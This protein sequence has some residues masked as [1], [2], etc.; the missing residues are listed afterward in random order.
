MSRRGIRQIRRISPAGVGAGGV[1]LPTQISGLQFWVRGDLGITLNGSNVS[2]WADQSGN[3]RNNTQGTAALQPAYNTTDANY[4]NQPTLTFNQTNTQGF[5]CSTFTAVP[6]PLTFI[7]VC[8]YATAVHTAELIDGS[9]QRNIIYSTGVNNY[10]IQ[11][12]GGGAG[13]IVASVNSSV[14]AVLGF[15]S[16]GASSAIFY[17]NSQTAAQTGSVGTNG[18]DQFPVG[19]GGNVQSW[20]GKVAEVIIYNFVLSSAQQFAV[21]HYLGVRYGISTS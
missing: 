8:N 20:N 1:F 3:G 9:V 15:V 4:N 12:L 11:A 19:L 18:M 14:P 6:Q 13:N 2:A 5:V 21:F 16:N 10:Q 17:N 7:F